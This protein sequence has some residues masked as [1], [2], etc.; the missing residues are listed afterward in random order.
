MLNQ[1][2]YHLCDGQWACYILKSL[3]NNCNRTYI[4]ST[5]S[6]CRRIRQHNRE[7]CG[8]AKS[9]LSLYPV[10]MFCIITGFTN[11]KM[12]LQCEW[13]LKH[14]EN[15]KKIIS[16][17]RGIIGRINGINYL[18][19]NSSKWKK[20]T[21]DCN[22]TIWINESYSDLLEIKKFNSNIKVNIIDNIWLMKYDIEKVNEQ[23]KI[24]LDRLNLH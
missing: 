8:G 24:D 13:L 18:L 15:K 17:Y 1:K 23:V 14:P 6:T 16:K 19:L 4:G 5:N 21:G 20:I 10:E 7:I 11:H 12:T 2:L 3:K 22:L 9:T